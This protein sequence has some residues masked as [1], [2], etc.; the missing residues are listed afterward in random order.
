MIEKV[1]GYLVNLR[2]SLYILITRLKEA[3]LT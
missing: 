3:K 1:Q 2:I